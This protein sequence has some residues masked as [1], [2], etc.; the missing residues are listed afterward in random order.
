[1]IFKGYGNHSV[2]NNYVEAN[3]KLSMFKRISYTVC[4]RIGE[5]TL[6][7]D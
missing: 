6:V 7:K 4:P 3:T 2:F 1:M 5:T